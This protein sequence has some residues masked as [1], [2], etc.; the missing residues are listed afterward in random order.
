[1]YAGAAAFLGA[2]TVTFGAMAMETI[3]LAVGGRDKFIGELANTLP[4]F[5]KI[6]GAA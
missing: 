4:L 2:S 5:D 1:M 6:I 3:I